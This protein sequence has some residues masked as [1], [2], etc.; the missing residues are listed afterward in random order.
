MYCL[1]EKLKFS[2]QIESIDVKKLIE[3]IKIYG[4][5]ENSNKNDENQK[6]EEFFYK[7]GKFLKD[8]NR[9]LFEFLEGKIVK[10]DI[11]KEKKE[12][13]SVLEFTQ[14]LISNKIITES[15]ILKN[16][17]KLFLS[18]NNEHIILDKFKSSLEFYYKK[19]VKNKEK[20]EKKDIS[21]KQINIDDLDSND[22]PNADSKV[23]SDTLKSEKPYE[24]DKMKLIQ[25]EKQSDL[26]KYEDDM[27]FIEELSHEETSRSKIIKLNQENSIKK[28]YSNKNIE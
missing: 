8:R 28:A 24:D 17:L 26:K 5:T 18:Q 2:E 20:Y 19:A 14:L 15:E 22:I 23:F 3:E 13:I 1:F 12:C 21:Q 11:E 7:I 9:K 25:I 4:V 27:D 6:N 10:I 16:I